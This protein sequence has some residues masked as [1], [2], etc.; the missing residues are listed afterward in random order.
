MSAPMPDEEAATTR[1]SAVVT[2]NDAEQRV[3]APPRDTMRN[4]D[5]EGD[6]S[7]SGSIAGAK[8]AAPTPQ[9]E[10]RAGAREA[11]SGGSVAP[12]RT[13]RAAAKRLASLAGGMRPPEVWENQ[14]PSLREIWHYAAYGQWTGQGTAGRIL[15]ITYAV[16]IA[17]PSLTLGYYALWVLERPARLVAALVLA[18]LVAL[19]P[20]GQFS[21]GLLLDLVRWLV[22]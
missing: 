8:A 11:S 2:A 7:T 19:T 22:T 18:T 3:A 13:C 17:I 4:R 16:V 21:L 15:G 12:G 14:R 6:G 10:A 1:T 5:A 9:R 20:P